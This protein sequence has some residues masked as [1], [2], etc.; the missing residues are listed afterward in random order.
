MRYLVT[1][2]I[3]LFLLMW[4][5]PPVETPT[6][7]QPFDGAQASS[8]GS[9]RGDRDQGIASDPGLTGTLSGLLA[10]VGTAFER[11]AGL[12]HTFQEQLWR[13]MSE[14]LR[15]VLGALKCLT[16]LLALWGLD[17]LRLLARLG[18]RV[19]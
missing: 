12:D 1:V 5:W 3:I 2:M 14:E 11:F 18:R 8:R 13:A 9:A 17:A 7:R 6:L 10:A 15:A 16:L 19:F 4:L